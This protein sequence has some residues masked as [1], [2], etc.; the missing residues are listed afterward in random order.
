MK[1]RQN[2]AIA[3]ICLCLAVPA[4]GQDGLR[5]F[6]FTKGTDNNLMFSNPAFLDSWKGKMSVA[7]LSFFKQDGA[8]KALE[9]SP[10]SWA[11]KAGTES[12]CR[13]SD[14]ICFHGDLSWY[15]FQGKGMGGQILM[16]P[17]YNPINFLENTESTSGLKK[18]ELYS[19]SG[20]MSLA[21]N[22]NLSLGISSKYVAGD[23]TKVKDPRFSNIWMDLNLDAGVRY[24]FSDNLSLG[25]SLKWRSTLE[26]FKGSIFGETGRQ[27]YID[28][29]KGGFFGTITELSG[30]N[31]YV[32]D[33]NF[34]PMK[35]NWY[36]AAVQ[37]YIKDCFSSEISFMLRD[38]YFGKKSSTSATFFEFS[39][40]KLAYDGMLTLPYGRNLRQLSIHA[41]FESLGNNENDVETTTPVGGSTIYIYKRQNHIFDR[42]VFSADLDYRWMRNVESSYPDLVLGARADFHSLTQ[43]TELQAYY[44]NQDIAHVEAAVYAQKTFPVK[45][46]LFSVDAALSA[47]T[48]FG[49][50]KDDGTIASS[51]STTLRSFDGYLD[52]HFE[53]ETAPRAGVSLAFTFT[54][55][56]KG[57]IAPYLKLSDRFTTLTKDNEYLDGKTRNAAA[58]VLG[59]NF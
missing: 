28:N 35:N 54:L 3:V 6:L 34:R 47:Y 56:C 7:E 11:L 2:T 1:L 27:Y 17:A 24:V 48:G 59:C 44:R 23:F 30:D 18:K 9:E 5:N 25:A 41:G 43:R 22:E 32:S 49:T 33:S 37:A 40:M 10:D 13:A 21:L 38:G 14:K 29:D 50:K 46:I 45:R 39:G 15:D 20:G 8:L 16:D 52:K 42:S 36:G 26:Q 55:P 51:S 19:L 53:F 31:N 12:Y 58:V 4:A 57:G